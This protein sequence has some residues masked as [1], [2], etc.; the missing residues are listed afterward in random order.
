MHIVYIPCVYIYILYNICVDIYLQYIHIGLD[1]KIPLSS[2]QD[3]L[4]VGILLLE[5]RS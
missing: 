3:L 2:G 1:V 5:D 4:T